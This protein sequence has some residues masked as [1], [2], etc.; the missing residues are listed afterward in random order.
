MGPSLSS[1]RVRLNFIIRKFSFSQANS[2]RKRPWSG[3]VETGKKNSSTGTRINTDDNKP[4]GLRPGDVRAH[5]QVNPQ[6]TT[7]LAFDNDFPA[8][9]PQ[10]PPGGEELI[11]AL[12]NQ[13]ASSE[14]LFLVAPARGRCRVLCFH[15]KASL[16]LP[17]MTSTEIVA[18]IE[19]WLTEFEKLS[20]TYTWVQVFEN[21]GAMMGCSVPHPHGQI[22]ASD[23]L[24]NEARVKHRTQREYYQKHGRPMLCD[25]LKRELLAK[26]RLILENNS[27]AVVVPFWAFWPFETML[28]PKRHVRRMNELRQEEVDHLAEIIKRLT[29]VYDNLFECSFPYS[30]GWHGAPTADLVNDSPDAWL[31]HAVYY[32]PLLRSASIKKFKAGYELLSQDQRDISP[33][34]AASRLR[35]IN[36]KVHYSVLE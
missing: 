26:E 11:E 36:D 33:E 17:L 32:P 29:T 16:S 23:F 15:P 21:K 19:A 7:T 20:A 12:R 24:P 10:L 28:L 9:T 5:G 6:Y 14:P 30:M 22:W 27:W 13:N 8:L 4:N 25:Y 18:V 34:T 2:N 31:L 1:S 3:Q 35:D